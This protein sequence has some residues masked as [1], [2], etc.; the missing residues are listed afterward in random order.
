MPK[1]TIGD[2]APDFMLEGTEGTFTLSEHR[3]ETVVLL[4]YPGDDTTVC[5]KQFCAYRDAEEDLAQLPATFVGISTQ[6]MESK[7]AF[8]S[9]YGLTTP[10]LADPGGTVARAYGVY[11]SPLGIARRAVII[12]D[13]EGRVAHQHRN[14][15]SLSFDSVSE[16]RDALEQVQGTAAAHS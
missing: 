6:G 7:R 14:F 1:L 15:M 2:P 12:V 4:F 13:P 5:T 16:I 10:L 9:K 8:K 3:G 11:A